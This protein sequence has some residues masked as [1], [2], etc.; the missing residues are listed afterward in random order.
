MV[1]LVYKRA[2]REE[3]RPSNKREEEENK[4][5]SERNHDRCMRSN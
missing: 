2:E 1:D 5:E 3:I 4:G